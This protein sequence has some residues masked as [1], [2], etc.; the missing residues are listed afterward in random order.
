[1]DIQ[2]SIFSYVMTSYIGLFTKR[3]IYE[4]LYDKLGS[5]E[6]LQLK[7]AKFMRRFNSSNTLCIIRFAGVLFC[8][9]ISTNV[10][11]SWFNQDVKNIF[12]RLEKGMS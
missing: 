1:M 12:R 11:T 8:K 2:E 5:K 10:L 9:K 6:T 7:F 3:P 4:T